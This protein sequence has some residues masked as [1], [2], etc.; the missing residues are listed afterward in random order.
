[1]A[2]RTALLLAWLVVLAL[3]AAARA[4]PIETLTVDPGK[5][6]ETTGT[7]RLDAGKRYTL[8]VS[9]T[10]S[11]VGPEGYGFS[12]DAL[13]CFAGVGFDHPECEHSGQS[14]D[15]AHR[16]GEFEIGISTELRF[17]EIDQFAVKGA[18]YTAADAGKPYDPGHAYTVVFYPPKTGFLKAGGYATY[19]DCS[20]C[21]STWSGGPVT[22]EISGPSGGTGSGGGGSGGVDCAMP[23]R[24][25]FA[26]ASKPCAFGAVAS[27]PLGPPDKPSDVSSADL[28]PATRE[29]A[30]IFDYAGGVADHVFF[31]TLLHAH[32]RIKDLFDGCLVM[33]GVDPG[34]FIDTVYHEDP[35]ARGVGSACL[36]MVAAIIRHAER[37][38]AGRAA[39]AGGCR[40]TYMPVWKAGSHPSRK[41]RRRARRLLRSRARASCATLSPTRMT[42]K[43]SARGTGTLNRTIGRRATAAAGRLVP[44]GATDKPNGRLQYSWG[45]AGGTR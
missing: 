20:S 31:A 44:K 34:D 9:G 40:V 14:G 26:A 5:A 8:K 35:V 30:V 28:H 6:S 10:F 42:A 13:Y 27:A 12:Y 16:G 36:L 33:G 4:G 39:A 37:Q 1:M 7:V 18:P 22:I 19:N 43:I 21:R 41:T 17:A 45:I 15:H 3:P 11:V 24:F 25:A 23:A 29:L 32:T 2:R 38:G